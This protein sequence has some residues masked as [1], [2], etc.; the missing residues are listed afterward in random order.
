MCGIAGV[1]FNSNSFSLE[2]PEANLKN[3]LHSMEHRGP[4]GEGIKSFE[5]EEWKGFFGHRRLSIID[6]GGGHQ[7][8][9]TS[10]ATITFNGEILNYKDLKSNSQFH[11][12]TESD[13]EV[14][15][16]GYEESGSQS[17][18]KLNG[19]F[20]F[21]LLDKINQDVYLCRDRFG[22]KPL[23]Y[24]FEEN[25]VFAFA[26][27]L[28]AL[29]KFPFIKK[30][31]NVEK[32]PLYFFHNSFPW[33]SSAIRGVEKILPGEFLTFRKGIL[34]KSFYYNPQKLDK[35]SIQVSFEDA[36]IE[37]QRLIKQAVKRH[38]IAD[39]PVGIF[40]SGGID[41][42]IVAYEASQLSSRQIET[43]SIG[44]DRP[45]FDESPYAMAIAKQINSKHH[46]NI[47]SLEDLRKELNAAVALLDEPLGD[48][49]IIPTSLVSKM[50]SRNV[51]VVLGGDGGDEVFAGYPMLKAHQLSE[52]YGPFVNM[53]LK[54]QGDKIINK[55]PNRNVAKSIE[56]KLKKFL[57]GW[58]ENSTI[59]HQ[60][61]MAGLK[62]DH[63]RHAF[64]DAS[65]FDFDFLYDG[66]FSQQISGNQL[67]L[68]DLMNFLANDV[69]TKVDR[70]S[71]GYSLEVRPPLLDND[72][73][74]FTFSLPF[75]FK[76]Q[77]G[78]SKYI[79]KELYKPIL[80]SSILY[81][82]KKGF[83]LPMAAWLQSDLGSELER[84]IEDSPL[85]S[86]SGPLHKVFWKNLLEV[87]RKRVQD[88]SVPLWN[89]Y[90]LSQWYSKLMNG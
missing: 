77:A 46:Q 29:L 65:R 35:A 15:L 44:F 48:S 41:S 30:E 82:A 28:S 39:V 2:N 38:L 78:H 25:K 57:N 52:I 12:K 9:E 8:M 68:F 74:D 19:F 60:N 73:V 22:I 20:A 40:L 58:N 83:S 89:F 47:V 87:H 59:R 55:L 18:E 42:S 90:V 80:P 64:K 13:T 7:P 4:D 88:N 72:L 10:G 54:L 34:K 1:I 51:K 37:T 71:M 62:I 31:L 85:T 50:A 56:W 32:L 67:L 26:S 75:K 81:R 70:A 36:K 43:F 33:N 84:M 14:I 3:V 24:Y 53:F 63:I 49:S 66:R 69:I 27:E 16:S 21:G 61:W 6:L 17:F 23:Y 45:D 86:E 5:I 11:F 79:L 76:Y